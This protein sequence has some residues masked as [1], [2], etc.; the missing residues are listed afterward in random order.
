[1]YKIV[2][3]YVCIIKKMFIDIKKQGHTVASES[4]EFW[5]KYRI[6]EESLSHV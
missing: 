3:M 2:C 1:M 4:S 5:S 6:V